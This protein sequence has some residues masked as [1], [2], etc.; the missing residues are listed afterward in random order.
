M[1]GAKVRAVRL[2]VI[3]LVA[4][5][6]AFTSS[7]AAGASRVEGLHG[8]V[9]EGPTKPVCRSDDACEEPA[10]GILLAFTRDGKVVAK[11][12]TTTLGTYS[13]RLKAGSYTVRV[14]LQRVGTGLSPRAVRVPRGRIARVDFHLDTGRQ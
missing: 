12:K 11:V 3:G 10:R 14:P 6:T 4:L 8:I 13:V 2:S 9:L 5:L 7:G 1:S